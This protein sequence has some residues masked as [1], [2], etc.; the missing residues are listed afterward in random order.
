MT[1]AERWQDC[2]LAV[3]RLYQV[4]D[5]GSINTGWLLTSAANRFRAAGCMDLAERCD[6]M[7]EDWGAPDSD[8]R[9]LIDDAAVRCGE[10]E[11]ETL[12]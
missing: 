6:S 4:I 8:V 5:A 3:T 7:A 1:A 2:S 10:F 11:R 9:A 12:E